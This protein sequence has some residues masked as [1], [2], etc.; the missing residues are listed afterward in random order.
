[1]KIK[2]VNYLMILLCI[3]QISMSKVK[4][5]NRTGTTVEV[6]EGAINMFINEQYNRAGFPSNIN[7]SLSGVTYDI[8]LY[9]P[10]IRLLNDQAKVEFGFNIA[11][12]VFNGEISFKDDIRFSVPSI[13]ELTVKGVSVAFKHK[14]KALGLHPVLKTLIINAWDSLE[15]EVYP[16]EL[17]KKLENSPWLVERSISIVEP[18]FSVS[19]DIDPQKLKIGLNTYLESREY[20]VAGLF[21]DRNGLSVK[22]GAGCQVNIKELGLYDLNGRRIRHGV[23]LGT[24]PKKGGLT[25]PI[26]GRIAYATYILKILYTTNNTFY[27]RGYKTVFNGYTQP[28]NVLN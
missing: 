11:S 7:G 17:A 20:L 18:Y 10:N 21:S 25:I 9:L 4:A 19:F 28:K 27:L 15:L 22:I 1:M 26:S 23:D 5:S 8:D 16:M 14:V 13:N 12:N 24:C 2:K 3:L 6:S